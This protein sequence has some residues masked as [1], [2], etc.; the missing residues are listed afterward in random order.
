M[1]LDHGARHCT[2]LP[3]PSAVSAVMRR[4]PG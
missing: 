1:A 4:A 2:A 3:L